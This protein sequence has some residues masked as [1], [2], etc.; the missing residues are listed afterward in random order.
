MLA[1]SC[2]SV[3]WPERLTPRHRATIWPRLVAELPKT[4]RKAA[5]LDPYLNEVNT[6]PG[7]T[8]VSMY[9]KLW[10]STGL[11]YPRLVDRLIELAL[12][13]HEA[14]RRLRTTRSPRGEAREA[15]KETR[16]A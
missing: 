8:P 15:G 1:A 7:F 10:E 3:R 9:P 6:L 5:T 12:E 4:I 13:R 16:G 14:K 11:S 2:R